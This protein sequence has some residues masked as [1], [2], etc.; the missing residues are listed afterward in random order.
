MFLEMLQLN[1]NFK[2]IHVIGNLQTKDRIFLSQKFKEL[3]INFTHL[4]FGE[5]EELLKNI[6]SI[7]KN[8]LILLTIPTPKQ[9]LLAQMIRSK[10][11]CAKIICIGGGLEIASGHEKKCPVILEKMGMEFI[12]RLRSETKRRVLRISKD[13]ITVIF[14]LI[15]FRLTK[16]KIRRYE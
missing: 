14:S 3:Y 1:K 9:E 5:P 13:I 4:P 7:E 16:L 12:W 8:S 11:D 15:T 10:F 6:T 2:Q